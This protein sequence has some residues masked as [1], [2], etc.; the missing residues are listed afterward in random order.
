MVCIYACFFISMR[1][2]EDL[3]KSKKSA[4]KVKN[5]VT[6]RHRNRK[7]SSIIPD[8]TP[9]ICLETTPTSTNSNHSR[10]QTT[11]TSTST[12]SNHSHSRETRS[13]TRTRKLVFSHPVTAPYIPPR[14][15]VYVCVYVCMLFEYIMYSHTYIL[16]LV[17]SCVHTLIFHVFIYSHTHSMHCVYVCLCE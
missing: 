7:Y 12:T 15:C 10:T 17:Y 16:I 6:A 11:R 3:S 14:R 5:T 1:Q 13:R 8:T 9:I 2:A 4:R